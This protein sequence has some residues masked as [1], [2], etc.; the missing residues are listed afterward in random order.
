MSAQ[1]N[2]SAGRVPAGASSGLPAAA[3]CRWCRQTTGQ[4]SSCCFL[5]PLL[6]PPRARPADELASSITAGP[7]E[8]MKS[9]ELAADLQALCRQR[10]EPGRALRPARA[11]LLAGWLAGAAVLLISPPAAMQ[12]PAVLLQHCASHGPAWLQQSKL[13]QRIVHVHFNASA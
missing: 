10:G 6:P 3:R 5:S 13:C 4:A 2:D 8:P 11:A 1:P 9:P 7:L 12:S